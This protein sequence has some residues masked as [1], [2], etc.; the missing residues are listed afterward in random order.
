MTFFE[1][2][3]SPSVQSYPST[4]AL[5]FSPVN[6]HITLLSSELCTPVILKIDAFHSVD[7][8]K[9]ATGTNKGNRAKCE[10]ARRGAQ[11]A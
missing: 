10:M 7:F 8:F 9:Q 5:K 6:E 11:F 2:D 4:I 1:S 3:I